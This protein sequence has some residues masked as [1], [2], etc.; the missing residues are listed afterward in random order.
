MSSKTS[1]HSSTMFAK[2]TNKLHE[3][4]IHMRFRN[5]TQLWYGITAITPTK[6]TQTY[7]YFDSCGNFNW[8]CP[9]NL[10]DILLVTFGAYPAE[11]KIRDA[12][13]PAEWFSS[14][15]VWIGRWWICNQQSPTR[16]TVVSRE[17]SLV[18]VLIQIQRD[19]EWMKQKFSK[20]TLSVRWFFPC[21]FCW[22]FKIQ[23]GLRRG[24]HTHR[25]FLSQNR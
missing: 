3:N 23:A 10:K 5:K 15:R 6:D 25:H 4:P 9:L 18:T 1:A 21:G 7:Q 22:F 13:P 17:S 20:C 11:N 8:S 2:I 24:L 12:K 16:L 14:R 19:Y